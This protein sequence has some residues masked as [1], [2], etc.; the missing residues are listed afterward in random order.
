MKNYQHLNLEEREQIAIGIALGKSYRQIGRELNRDHRTISREVKRNRSYFQEYVACE[1]DRRAKKKGDKQRIRAPLK[2]PLIFL[3]VREKLRKRWSPEMISGRLSIVHPGKHIC[4][5]TIY[6]YIYRRDNRRYQ[7]WKYL[8]RCRKK[9]MKKEGRKV[10]RDGRI[11]GS[12]SIDLRPKKVARRKEVGH[13]E[14]DN[15]EGRRRDRSVVTV[16]VE[17]VTRYVRISKLDNRG[18]A[19]KTNG[20]INHLS[21]VP[22]RLRLTLTV[23]NGKE[24]SYHQQITSRLSLP[25]YFCHAYHSW[26]KGTVENTIGRI[27][28]YIPKGYSLDLIEE[29]YLK[30]LEEKLNNTPRKC[31][32]YL[33]PSEK[34]AQVLSSLNSS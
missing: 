7:L 3:Y 33:T 26:E 30:G 29:G 10:R 14:S 11:P 19:A 16:E 24:N 25:V 20:I 4:P 13:W 9:R 6:R 17:R 27:R 15:M 28:Q 32:G 8:S 5:E 31:L 21:G 12:V 18:A 2:D 1:A 23:D 22:E 34:M